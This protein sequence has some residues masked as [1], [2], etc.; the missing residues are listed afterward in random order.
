MMVGSN[1][2]MGFCSDHIDVKVIGRGLLVCSV[3]SFKT[4]GDFLFVD[5]GGID[6]IT[7]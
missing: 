6:D 3:S 2:L 1:R 5:I 4:G 7:V